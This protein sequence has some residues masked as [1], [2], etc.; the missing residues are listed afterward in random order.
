VWA[1]VRVPYVHFK[2]FVCLPKLPEGAPTSE[3]Y[4]EVKAKAGVRVEAP[5]V[6]AEV[7]LLQA[8]RKSVARGPEL[9][10]K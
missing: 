9:K 7:L 5:V 3:R 4:P 10:R 8:V 2:G 6:L 1:N